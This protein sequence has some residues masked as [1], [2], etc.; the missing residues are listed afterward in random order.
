MFI[1]DLQDVASDPK[2]GQSTFK[3]RR[4]TI[5]EFTDVAFSR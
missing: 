5:I 3:T 1:S 2:K 4:L